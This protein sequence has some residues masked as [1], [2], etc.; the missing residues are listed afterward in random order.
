MSAI[1]YIHVVN[2]GKPFQLDAEENVYV[3]NLRS[4]DITAE[5]SV[6][7]TNLMPDAP[8]SKR[9]YIVNDGKPNMR[10]ADSRVFVENLSGLPVIIRVAWGLIKCPICHGK[11]RYAGRLDYACDMCRRFFNEIDLLKHAA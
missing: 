10:R 11:L 6:I 3:V 5:R 2:D 4:S 1:E 9:V 7:V 8:R